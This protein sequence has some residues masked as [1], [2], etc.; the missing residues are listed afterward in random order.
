MI[1]AAD[2][3]FY[4]VL[5]RDELSLPQWL[6][7][8]ALVQLTLGY[9]APHHNV[10]LPIALLSF[11]CTRFFVTSA[12]YALGRRPSGVVWGKHTALMPDVGLPDTF[13]EKDVDAVS[14]SSPIDTAPLFHTQS[15]FTQSL[16]RKGHESINLAG[17]E[18]DDGTAQQPLTVFCFG[19]QSHHPLGRLAPGVPQ[20][21]RYTVELIKYAG[22]NRELSGYLGHM[23]AFLDTSDPSCNIMYQISYWK[24]PEHVQ[25]F[26]QSDE[27]RKCAEWFTQFS[28]KSPHIGVLHEMW[29]SPRGCWQNG[30]ES[31]KP[32]GLAVTRYLVPG[33][34]DEAQTVP[35][36]II[37]SGRRLVNMQS[38][39]GR[40][41]S[42]Q[43]SLHDK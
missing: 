4:V 39:F 26:T 6:L 32:R 38:R 43:G 15:G 12:R 42:H 29:H 20:F 16:N 1:A 33:A 22:A 8:G 24:S 11:Y 28:A 37:T 19:M 27:H 7:V 5:L 40:R 21:L 14:P 31:F 41:D 35:A 18:G 36:K 30:Y 23:P 3:Q 13:D 25:R 10:I 17:E 34:A 2:L 9:L